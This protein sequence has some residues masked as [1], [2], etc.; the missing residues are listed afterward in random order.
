[1]EAYLKVGIHNLPESGLSLEFTQKPETFTALAGMVE[2]GEC[3]FLSPV[4]VRLRLEEVGGLFHARGR[5]DALVQMPC[6]RCL[7]KV[8][9]PLSDP[10]SLAYTRKPPET[11]TR[12]DEGEIELKAQDMGL[13]H[14]QGDEI[15]FREAI[16]EQIQLALPMQ[17]LCREDCAGLCPGCGADLNK[18]DCG[19]RKSPPDPRFAVLERLKKDP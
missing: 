8:E 3:D 16:Q 15:D 9:I 1:M 10:F 19:C 11:E 12:Q 17:P 14:F 4:R 7:A 18:E 5:I 13:I 6:S 2:K